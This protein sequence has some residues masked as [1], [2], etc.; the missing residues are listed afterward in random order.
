MGGNFGFIH[1]KIEIK[2]L[3][4]FILRRLREPI[5]FSMLTELTMCDNGISYF[6]YTE[7][8]AELIKTEHVELRDN[9]YS[10][11]AKGVRN[12]EIT[13]NSLPYSVR[14]KVENNTGA[15]RNMLNRNT[16]IKTSHTAN[17]D[18][19]HTVEL[20]LSDGIGDI[21]TMSLYSANEKQALALERGF[22]KKA[23]NIYNSLIKTI[24]E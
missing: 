22:R 5:T 12:G 21:V 23:E 17:S 24:L 11:T 2:I 13:E 3:I 19:G 10:I 7:C 6:D 18:S 1:E 15:A 16:M 4:L 14:I 9:K 8:V 20:S